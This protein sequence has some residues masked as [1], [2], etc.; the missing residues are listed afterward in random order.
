VP[1]R[2]LGGVHYRALRDGVDPWDD[3][4]AFIAEH[5]DWLERFVAEHGV[6]PQPPRLVAHM[7]F[8]GQWLEWLG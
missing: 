6:R 1:L 2:I 5:R 7:G 3:V 8:H 4:P